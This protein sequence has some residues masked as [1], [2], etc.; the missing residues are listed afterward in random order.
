MLINRKLIHCI[1][2]PVVMNDLANT[3]LT[4]GDSPIMADEIKEICEISKIAYGCVI[5]M[6]LMNDREKSPLKNF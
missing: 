4:V 1:T 5:N 6:G 2:N 3:N